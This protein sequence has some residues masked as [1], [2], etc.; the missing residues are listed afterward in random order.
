MSD[1]PL[2]AIQDSRQ[3]A[4][5][6][7]LYDTVDHCESYMEGKL[8]PF[9]NHLQVIKNLKRVLE[10]Y[11]TD[12]HYR[13]LQKVSL[14]KRHPTLTTHVYAIFEELIEHYLRYLTLYDMVKMY[15]YSPSYNAIIG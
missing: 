6:L 7:E 5:L 12:W 10:A 14:T 9:V 3:F 2:M 13:V 4:K 1:I 11:I 15:Y 8:V